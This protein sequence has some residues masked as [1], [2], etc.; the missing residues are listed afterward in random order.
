MIC[1]FRIRNG[2]ALLLLFYMVVTG[3]YKVG[4]LVTSPP[5]FIPAG[6]TTANVTYT[7]YVAAVQI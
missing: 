2:C 5:T 6:V 1:V 3:C 4:D 7:N